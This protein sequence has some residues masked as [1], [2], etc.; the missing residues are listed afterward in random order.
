[1]RRLLLGEAAPLPTLAGVGG[2]GMARHAPQTVTDAS[3]DYG[4]AGFV[5]VVPVLVQRWPEG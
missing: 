3:A 5:T 2:V 1:M 4:S